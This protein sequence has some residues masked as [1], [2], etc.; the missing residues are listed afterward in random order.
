MRFR[1]GRSG[2]RAAVYGPLDGR[3]A[4]LPGPLDAAASLSQ[5][6]AVVGELDLEGKLFAGVAAGVVYRLSPDCERTQR[7]QL[8]RVAPPALLQGAQRLGIAG[9]QSDDGGPHE[10][11]PFAAASVWL[12]PGWT[13]IAWGCRGGVVPVVGVGV[14]RAGRSVR[15]GVGDCLP[16]HV[17][18][19]F[20]GRLA[21]SA[22]QL[23]EFLRQ[24][25]RE[26]D[27]DASARTFRATFWGFFG[28]G[29]NWG[30]I[31]TDRE[32]GKPAKN[33]GPSKGPARV[34]ASGLC[35]SL[36]GSLWCSG[37]RREL[38]FVA[39]IDCGKGLVARASIERI[40][41]ERRCELA[42]SGGGKNF[43]GRSA[44]FAVSR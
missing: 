10:A 19:D 25:F 35:G 31:P 36:C 32:K 2:R 27:L 4:R 43:V 9:V 41:V 20:R 38:Q 6:V 26:R 17:R 22:G 21:R 39:G 33:F 15:L 13:A 23:V 37:A 12:K 44:E 16:D 11:A 14:L 18:R 40:V 8:G 3:R 5:G 42:G 34:R 7:L 29:S 30:H 28:G 24:G 1:L